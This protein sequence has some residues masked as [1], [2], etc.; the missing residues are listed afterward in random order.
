MSAAPEV[1]VAQNFRGCFA[2]ILLGNPLFNFL[3]T[4]LSQV[5]RCIARIYMQQVCIR[6]DLECLG[7]ILSGVFLIQHSAT[8]L[9]SI[10]VILLHKSPS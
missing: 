1:G 10:Y 6:A 8:L 2:P 7:L 4:P 9:P 3:A 5:H